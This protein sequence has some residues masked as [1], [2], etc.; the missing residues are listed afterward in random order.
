MTGLHRKTLIR[1]TAGDMRRKPRH[2]HRGRT[3]GVEVDDALPVI[4]ESLDYMTAERLQPNSGVAQ[5]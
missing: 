4:G 2:S 3:Y 5:G 1:R